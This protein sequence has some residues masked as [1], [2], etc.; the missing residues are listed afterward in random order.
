M[1]QIYHFSRIDNML[2]RICAVQLRICTKTK[3]APVSTGA[4]GI[5][6]LNY[7]FTLKAFTPG[8]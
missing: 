6:I 8:K 3:K 7:Y 5:N 2:M 4:F 1:K